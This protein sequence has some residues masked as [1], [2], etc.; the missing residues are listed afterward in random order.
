MKDRVRSAA[1]SPTD[2]RKAPE[3]T[4]VPVHVTPNGGRCVLG[5]DLVRSRGFHEAVESM[6]SIEAK[7][8][9]G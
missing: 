8:R 5:K 7:S 1:N 4:D 3:L 6:K 9:G 2:R